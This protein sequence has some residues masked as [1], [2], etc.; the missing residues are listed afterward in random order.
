MNWLRQ[1]WSNDLPKEV[2]FVFFVLL[3]NAVPA[4]T[5]LM[6]LPT[7]TEDLF[8]WTVTPVINARLMG[9]M[10]ANALLL[11]GIGFFQ[12][13]WARVRIIMVVVTLFSV[14]ATVLTFFYLKPFLAHPWFHLTYWLGMYLILFFA[15]PYVLVTQEKKRGG[16]LPIQIPLSTATRLVAGILMLVS[17]ACGLAFL[18]QIETVNQVWPWKLPPLVGGLIGVL[19][20][21]HAAAYAWALWDGD[22][23]RIRPMFWQ[24]PPTGLL[25]VLLP[26]LHAA[27][28]RPDMG[29]ALT[30]Y[31]ALAGV[32]VL[33]SLGIIL[34]YHAAEKK[35]ASHDQ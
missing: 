21:T 29:A 15:A 35:I 20:T 19:F 25:F 32:A 23:L 22:W 4:I 3:A 17:L 13:N 1:W 7:R 2:K 5:I 27:D 34:S 31:Y 18:F 10:Y 24:A 16:R 33:L 8:V 28:L 30:L 11:V 26:L 14:L 6:T 12:P 9:V